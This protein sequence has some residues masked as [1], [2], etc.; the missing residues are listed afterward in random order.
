M[1]LV[2]TA[3]V[4]GNYVPVE[5]GLYDATITRYEDSE[6]HAE[7]GPGVKVFF[8]ID[9]TDDAGEDGGRE[10]S[11]LASVKFSEKAKLRLWSE[12]AI[13]RKI[14][15]DEEFELDQIVGKRVKIKV[16]H[17][18]KGDKVYDR[19]DDVI[20]MRKPKGDKPAVEKSV[21][22]AGRRF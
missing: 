17:V 3:T 9:E 6:P 14:E 21:A 12:A 13:G 2:L 5:E 20:P 16:V 10:L 7:Y 22:Q 18:H 8:Q 1:G 15:P 19:I 11:G 4:G